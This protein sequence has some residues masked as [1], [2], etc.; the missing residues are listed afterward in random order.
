MASEVKLKQGWLTRDINRASQR[1]SQW[2][3]AHNSGQKLPVQPSKE[4]TAPSSKKRQ[5]SGKESP[6]N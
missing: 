5:S 6:K 3:T 1:T 4:T 2:E